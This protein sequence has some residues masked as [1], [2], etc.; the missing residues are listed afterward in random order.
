MDDQNDQD[1]RIRLTAR[2]VVKQELERATQRTLDRMGL[3][4]ALANRALIERVMLDVLRARVD[5]SERDPIA[6]I[7]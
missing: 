7:R 4:D 6:R 3:T 5:R 1:D 2:L